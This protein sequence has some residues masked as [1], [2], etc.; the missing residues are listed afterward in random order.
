MVP[1]IPFQMKSKNI[2]N[3]HTDHTIVITQ[4]HI[5]HGDLLAS[6]NY[7]GIAVCSALE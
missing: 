4:S 7:R 1:K 2:P 6:D 3:N 5:A